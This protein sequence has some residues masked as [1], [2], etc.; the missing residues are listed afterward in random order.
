MSNGSW[1]GSTFWSMI[2]LLSWESHI[3]TSSPVQGLRSNNLPKKIMLQ[4]YHITQTIHYE[5]EILQIFHATALFDFPQKWEIKLI[6]VSSERKKKKSAKTTAQVAI[7]LTSQT[8]AILLGCNL[9]G[10]GVVRG[11][12][13][14]PKSDTWL[15]FRFGTRAEKKEMV[16]MDSFKKNQLMINWWF[17]FLGSAYERDYYFGVPLECQ[18]TNPTTQTTS[19][20]LV[21]KKT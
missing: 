4:G 10:I 13:P 12:Y 21:E 18:T 20:P 3:R 11:A 19:L 7:L 8:A 17:G 14:R 15:N 9:W 2:Q 6:P 1:V 16:K 5:G